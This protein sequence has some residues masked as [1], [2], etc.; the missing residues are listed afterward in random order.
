[1]K[2]LLLYAALASVFAL[3]SCTKPAPDDDT[4]PTKTVVKPVVTDPFKG[5]VVDTDQEFLAYDFTGLWCHACGSYGIPKFKSEIVGLGTDRINPISVHRTDAW[6]NGIGDA[7]ISFMPPSAYP[8]F[9]YNLTLI[10]NSVFACHDSLSKFLGQSNTPVV[11]LGL[12]ATTVSTD[13]KTMTVYVKTKF[14]QAATGTYN[15]AV[16]VTEDGI[17]ANQTTDGAGGS[18]VQEMMTH[19]HILRAGNGSWLGTQLATGTVTPIAAN[20]EYQST[21][22]ITLDVTKGW[23][24]ANMHV[25][26]AIFKMNGS[27]PEKVENSNMR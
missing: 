20:K 22:K 12:G 19:D 3:G 18:I 9:G 10:G 4:A 2:K 23:D 17:K 7:I 15:I 1:M 24:P 13:G 8:S 6:S 21:I 5:V 26:A 16:Y 11:G 14:L 25:I 27:T